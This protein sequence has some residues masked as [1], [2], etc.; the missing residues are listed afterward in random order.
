MFNFPQLQQSKTSEE[1][2]QLLDGDLFDLRCNCGI[3]VPSTSFKLMPELL[4]IFC[5]HFLIHSVKSELD[6]LKE[7]LQT[8]NLLSTI[9]RH[10]LKFLPLFTATDRSE[11]TPNA[12]ISLFKVDQWSPE[13]SNDREAEEALIFNWEHYVRETAGILLLYKSLF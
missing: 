11:L 9:Q 7:G 13:G 3:T 6:Q 12:L 10:P 5:L 1:M 4:Q 2:R 8:L